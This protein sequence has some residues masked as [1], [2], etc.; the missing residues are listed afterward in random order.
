MDSK[1]QRKQ[2]MLWGF[3]PSPILAGFR[4]RTDSKCINLVWFLYDYSR[5]GLKTKNVFILSQ[6]WS[7]KSVS[8]CWNQRCQQNCAPLESKSVLCIIQVLAPANIP[9][10]RTA[11]LQSVPRSLDCLRSVCAIYLCLPPKRIQVMLLGSIWRIQDHIY[12]DFFFPN[13]R[14]FTGFS[15]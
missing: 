9:C 3:I 14:T 8:L 15:A 10:L 11:F 4:E 5:E 1:Y 6:F 7:P 12:K 13:K 2:A